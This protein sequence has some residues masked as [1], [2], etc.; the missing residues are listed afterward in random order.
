MADDADRAQTHTDREMTARIAAASGDIPTGAK[1]WCVRCEAYHP[2]L[3]G[4]LCV[5]CRELDEQR[6]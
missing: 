1:G 4:G 3:I 2:R 5:A 6:L